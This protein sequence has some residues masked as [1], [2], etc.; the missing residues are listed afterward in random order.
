MDCVMRPTPTHFDTW[1]AEKEASARARNNG[2]RD[3]GMR[4]AKSLDQIDRESVRA[5]SFAYCRRRSDL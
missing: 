4:W 3:A 1:A 5:R 2:K